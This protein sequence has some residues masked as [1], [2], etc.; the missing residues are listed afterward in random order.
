MEGGEEVRRLGRGTA[1]LWR[2]TCRR[3][4]VCQK[5]VKEEAKLKGGYES[6]LNPPLLLEEKKKKGTSWYTCFSKLLYLGTPPKK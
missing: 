3:A 1:A 4:L 5:L 2:L 6:G